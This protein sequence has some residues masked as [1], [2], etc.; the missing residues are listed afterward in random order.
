MDRLTTDIM[1]SRNLYH[2]DCRWT[3]KAMNIIAPALITAVSTHIASVLWEA[4]RGAE[5]EVE[6]L[7]KLLLH[8]VLHLL[9]LCGWHSKIVVV[10]LQL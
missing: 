10:R 1:M 3:G 7:L 2:S 5:E 8:V 4:P 6:D 9:P